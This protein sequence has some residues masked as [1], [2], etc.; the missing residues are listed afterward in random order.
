MQKKSVVLGLGMSGQGALR[1][2]VNQG[3]FVLGLDQKLTTADG[4]KALAGLQGPKVELESKE[5]IEDWT[6]IE[7]VV[8]SP[9]ISPQHPVYQ[10]ARERNIP[11]IG[12]AELALS[13]ICQPM[14]AITGT[15]GK[16]TVT[17]LVEHVFN[18]SGKKSVALGNVGVS[19]CQYLLEPSQAEI[20]VVELSSYQLETM[21]TPVFEA[22]ALLNITPDHLD[23]YPSF[24]EYARTKCRM[25]GLVKNRGNCF[26]YEQV[27]ADYPELLDHPQLFGWNPSCDLWIEEGTVF[28][29]SGRLFDFPSSDSTGRHDYENGVA[30]FALC[31]SFGVTPEQFVHGLMTF[32]K[33][34]HRI[35]WI[36]DINGVSYY[37]DSKGTNV[38]ATIQAVKAMK[39]PVVL[40][41]GGVDKG[42]SYLA[43]KEVFRGRV[44]VI[45][46]IGQAAD[47]IEQELGGY[48][49]V[50]RCDSM[51]SAVQ[52]AFELAVNHDCVL[53]SPGC[54]SFDMFN[55]YAHRGQEYQKYIDYLLEGECKI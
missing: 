4:W 43:W 8:V 5:S 48:Y 21:T 18:L 11:V 2:L 34:S 28:D 1:W 19:L 51:Q 35:E 10:G 26:V 37:D 16:T 55:D 47:K 40:I 25:P 38:D 52:M 13:S 24:Y 36:R 3:H 41:A 12:E 15:N 44:K 7:Q 45:I 9:G 39:G 54:A 23:R 46:A 53:L 22:A 31:R 42:F 17:K 33:P 27:A 29:K 14:V 49:S 6:A 50:R 30:A 32:K 20:V